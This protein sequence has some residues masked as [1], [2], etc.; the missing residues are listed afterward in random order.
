MEGA[1]LPLEGVVRCPPF[2]W[3]NAVFLILKFLVISTSVT[4]PHPACHFDADSDP[5]CHLDV[6]PA[7]HFD[8]DPDPSVP[9]T[10]M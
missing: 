10:W 8:A 2:R 4:D 6:D 7:C 9:F 3:D 1:A 5:A